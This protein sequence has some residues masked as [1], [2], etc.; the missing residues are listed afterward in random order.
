VGTIQRGLAPPE[1]FTR[2][3]SKS[4]MPPPEMLVAMASLIESRLLSSAESARG[5]WI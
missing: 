2:G 5:V 1:I 4:E 3:R